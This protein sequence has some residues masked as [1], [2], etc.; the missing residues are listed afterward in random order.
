MIIYINKHTFHYEAENL[1]RLFFP[2]T[3]LE[4]VKDIPETLVP[5]YVYTAL[6]ENDNNVKIFVDVN[7]DKYHEHSEKT[8]SADNDNLEL[9]MAL[10]LF[11]H[12]TKLTDVT[13]PWGVLTGVRPIKLFRRL[14]KEHSFD[15]AVDYFINKFKVSKEK[16]DLTIETEKNERAILELSQGNSY[17][18][19]ISIPFCPSRC[20]YCSIV[21]A[22]V[23]RTK[24]VC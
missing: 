9:E 4:V 7:I 16:T 1:T 12:F 10:M 22:S 5:P 23:E 8:F 20:S 24:I 19:Y 15:Y 2:N 21:S 6:T 13:P 14:A 17:S 18:L 3:K 11:E